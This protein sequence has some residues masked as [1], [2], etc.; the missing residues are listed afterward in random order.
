M[1]TNII[2][3]GLAVPLPKGLIPNELRD[4]LLALGLLVSNESLF[5]LDGSV[6]VLNGVLNTKYTDSSYNGVS[7][8]ANVLKNSTKPSRVPWQCLLQ[9]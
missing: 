4:N 5:L 3:D 2:P 9:A 8:R 1:L 7:E 6:N